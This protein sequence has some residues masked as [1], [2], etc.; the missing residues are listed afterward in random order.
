MATHRRLDR[1]GGLE[2]ET[3]PGTGSPADPLAGPLR[4]ANIALRK[5]P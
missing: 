2:V 1:I 4:K 3:A 5:V